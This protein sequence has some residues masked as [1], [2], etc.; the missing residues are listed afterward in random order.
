MTFYS[1][2]FTL[3]ITITEVKISAVTKLII[4]SQSYT[5]GRVNSTTE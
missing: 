4:L 5:A 1:T 2:K 3:G